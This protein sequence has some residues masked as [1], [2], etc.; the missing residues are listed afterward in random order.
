MAG[1]VTQ[2]DVLRFEISVDKSERMQVGQSA[3]QLRDHPLAAVLLHADLGR[4]H[5]GN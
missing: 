3:A 2:E 1:G 4:V 5:G